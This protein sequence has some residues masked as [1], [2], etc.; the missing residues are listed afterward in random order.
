[1]K[2]LKRSLTIVFAVLMLTGGLVLSAEAQTRRTIIRRPVYRPVIVRRVYYNP[3]YRRY[4]DPFYYDFYRSPYERYLENRYYAE[5]ELA[6][7]Q[8]ELAKHQAKYRADGIIT[9]KER[10]ELEDD[11][12]DVQKAR[13]KLNRLYRNY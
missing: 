9:A 3:F 2:H 12:R 10:R 13:A 4:Y 8:R 5:R 1:M 11:I 7:N 6:G